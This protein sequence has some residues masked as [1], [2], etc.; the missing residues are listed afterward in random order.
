MELQ[1]I[2]YKDWFINQKR[3]PDKESQEC[4]PFFDFH[5]EL[6]LNGA[7][8]GG[9]YINPFLTGTLIYGIQK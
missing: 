9:T 8:M 6:C 5:R 7:M 3:I 4:K 1:S 2:D